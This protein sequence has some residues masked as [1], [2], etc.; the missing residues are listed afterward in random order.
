MDTVEPNPRTLVRRALTITWI[1]NTLAAAGIGSAYFGDALA[2]AGPFVRLFAAA[3]LVSSLATLFLAA[4]LPLIVLVLAR[5]PAGVIGYVQAAWWTA[6]LLVV[7]VDTRV[8]GLFRYHLNGMVWNL[9]TTPGGDENFQITTGTWIVVG[10][11]AVVVFVVQVLTWKLVLARGARHAAR[12]RFAVAALLAVVVF[13]RVTYAFADARRD[14]SITARAALFPAYQRL[15]MKRTL[16]RFIAVD[17]TS[18]ARL[19]VNRDGSLL[20]YPLQAPVVP[21]D[22]PRANVLVIVIDS[23]RSD[24]LTPETMPRITEWSRDARVFEDHLSGGNATRFGI[25]A[26]VY[27]IHG[28]YWMPVYEENAPPV[29]VTALAR[30]GFDLRVISSAKM[31]YPEFRSTAWVTIPDRVEDGFEQGEKY[32]RD[33]A[34]VARFEQFLAERDARG[35]RAPFFCFTLLDAPHQ[36]YSWPPEE[37]FFEPA[38]RSLDYLDLARRP[39]D[40]TIASIRNSYENAVRFSDANARRMID[41][42]ARHGVLEDTFVIVTG[43]HGE[44]FFENGYFGHTSNFTPEQVHVAFVMSGPGVTP[45]VES[46][47]TAHVDLAPTLLEAFGVDPLRRAEWSQ[48]WNLL[49]PPARRERVIAG[50]QEVALW[51][52]GGILHV[53]LEG[54][55]G[56]VEARDRHWRPLDQEAEFVSAHGRAIADLALACRKFLR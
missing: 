46:R 33:T 27:G 26:L 13:E 36:T 12:L 10:L 19:E 11:A 55:R 9:L 51:V 35:E 42:L 38:P 39:D 50:W 41:A 4:G 31:S 18:D 15:T 45:G 47:P 49:A 20:R 22:G 32:Q 52:D 8:Y 7:F 54:H 2:G 48:G 25:F 43:D 5:V 37:T 40:A 16:A 1:G 34:V 56:L 23:L 14:R 21:A 29:L 30:A 24:Q 53:P 28:T 6:A 17:T 3:A 44:E